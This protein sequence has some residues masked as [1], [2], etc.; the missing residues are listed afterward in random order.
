MSEGLPRA[1]AALSRPSPE[2]SAARSGPMRHP[3]RTPL[4][5]CSACGK[6]CRDEKGRPERSSSAAALVQVPSAR[7]RLSAERCL[8]DECGAGAAGIAEAARGRGGQRGSELV[9]VRGAPRSQRGGTAV[10]R[11]RSHRCLWAR[12]SCPQHSE[13][14]SLCLQLDWKYNRLQILRIASFCSET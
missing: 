3:H 7:G 14:C 10:L 6:R 11:E 5:L 4:L 2:A 9:Q 1:R 8:P 13:W 12:H